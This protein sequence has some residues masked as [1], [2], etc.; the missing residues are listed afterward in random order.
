MV[1]G[2]DEEQKQQ[3]SPLPFKAM[4]KSDID[5]VERDPI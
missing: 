2:D 5:L 4:D 3:V 1:K